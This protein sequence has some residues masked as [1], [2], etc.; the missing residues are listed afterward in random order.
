MPGH[1]GGGRLSTTVASAL[2]VA[3][4]TGLDDAPV[5]LGARGGLVAV[6]GAEGAVRVL[7]ERGAFE[8]PAGTLRVVFAPD[9]RSLAVTGPMGYALWRRADGRAIVREFGG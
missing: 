9:A 1:G 8:L 7:D 2:A 3:W 4:E 6:A 5:A